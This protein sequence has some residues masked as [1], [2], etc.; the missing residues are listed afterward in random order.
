MS[1]PFPMSAP[2]AQTGGAVLTQWLEAFRRLSGGHLFARREPTELAAPG[3]SAWW[4]AKIA[5]HVAKRRG[6]TRAMHA[7]WL[8]MEQANIADLV[9]GR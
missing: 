7:A 8:A 2:S 3:L 5:Y 1:A 9:A 4:D 6:D